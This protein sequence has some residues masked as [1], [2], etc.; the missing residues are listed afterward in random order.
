MGVWNVG[1]IVQS[2]QSTPDIKNPKGWLWVAEKPWK[3]MR[4][5]KLSRWWE[6]SA[7]W[8]IRLSE[9]GVV[10]IKRMFFYSHY[11]ENTQPIRRTKQNNTKQNNRLYVLWIQYIIPIRICMY[12]HIQWYSFQVR[13]VKFR[14]FKY[15]KVS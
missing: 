9:N 4:R 5:D 1:W 12:T 13:I 11:F 8:S 2:I 6:K 3:E 10:T 7:Q 15:L 14:E